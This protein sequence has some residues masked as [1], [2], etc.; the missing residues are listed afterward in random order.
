VYIFGVF[1]LFLAKPLTTIF[2]YYEHNFFS[3]ILFDNPSNLFYY[4]IFP[5]LY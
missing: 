3:A 1:V 2:P 5:F 4:P